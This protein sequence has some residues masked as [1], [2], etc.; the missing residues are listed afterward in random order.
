VKSGKKQASRFIEIDSL[1]FIA[2]AFVIIQHTLI[3]FT[4]F[5]TQESLLEKIILI[6]SPGWLGVLIFFSISG[7]VIPSSLKGP[8]FSALKVFFKRRFLRLYPPFWIACLI[9]IILDPAKYSISDLLWRVSMLPVEDR[10]VLGHSSYFWTLQIE[11]VFYFLIAFLFSLFGRFSWKFF[12]SVLSILTI[13]YAALICIIGGRFA[14][15]YNFTQCLPFSILLMI[16]GAA[17]RAIL[18]Q[19]S[20]S[21]SI[22]KNKYSRAIKLGLTTGI[23]TVIPLHAVYFGTLEWNRAQLHEG[24]AT[25]LGVFIF[26]FLAILKPIKSP[27][28]A[29]LGR[30]TYS[31]YLLHGAVNLALVYLLTRSGTAGWPLPYLLIITLVCSFIVGEVFYQIIEIPSNLLGRGNKRV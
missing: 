2:C 3:Y 25:I 4:Q 8:R 16:W 23:L 7:F 28:L 29:R 11:L 10:N 13:P 26:L 22:A 31:T 5:S 19:H 18:D 9:I 17:C 20:S 12:V 30:N 14:P 27:A 15:F 24:S 21:E 1:R 6:L